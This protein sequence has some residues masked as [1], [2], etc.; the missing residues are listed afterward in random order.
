MATLSP[1]RLKRP[2]DPIK[3]ATFIADIAT[4]K[5]RDS[6]TELPT[7][8]EI[9]RVMSALGRM[10]GLKGGK[11]RAESLSAKERTK[12]ALKAARAR[13]AKKG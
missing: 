5:T 3:L 12:I 13:W 11:A 9:S 8:D 10:G 2:S 6:T 1:K 4:D 7:K